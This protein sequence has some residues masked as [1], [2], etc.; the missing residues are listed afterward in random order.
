M[1]EHAEDRALFAARALIAYFKRENNTAADHR[2]ARQAL[3]TINASVRARNTDVAKL[4]LTV[5]A[6][7]AHN[8]LSRLRDR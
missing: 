4:R 2:R 5:R 3:A 8:R 6:Q 1:T 7:N